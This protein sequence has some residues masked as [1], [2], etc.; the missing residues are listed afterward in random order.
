M[1]KGGPIGVRK[2][3]VLVGG[4]HAHLTVLVNLASYVQRG[5]RV[6][7]INPSPY[8]YYSGM[9]PGML[10]GIYRP[11]E[12][13]FHVKKMTEDRGGEF[14]ED[15][16]VKIDPF[17]RNLFLQGGKQ[18]PYDV[19]SFNTGSEVPLD[20]LF[21]VSQENIIPVK[22]VENLLRVHR[23]ILPVLKSGMHFTVIGGG[24]AGVEI[25]ANLWRLV[26]ESQGEAKIILIAGRK[27][28]GSFPEK[29][30][31][32]ALRSLS[33]RGIEVLEGTRVKEIRKELVILSE[34]RSLPFDFAFLALGIRPSSI[35]HE[36]GLPTGED[37]GLRVN[38]HLQSVAYPELFG[39]GD[40]ISLSGHP[41]AKVGVHAVRQNP[42]LFRN[43]VAALEGGEMQ[44]FI[45]QEDYLQILNMGDGRG[46]LWKKSFVWEGRLAFLLKDYI[47]RRFMRNFQVSGELEEGE[48]AGGE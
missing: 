16:V 10:S 34:G 21:A 9:S 35:F 17:N 40:C 30:R 38:S 42:L 3:L 46:I 22:P 39:G 29:V 8:Q 18:L 6:T 41:L 33:R 27:L 20:L 31:T 44:T 2:H 43:L 32:L 19:A 11:R 14:I 37:G 25:A 23:L 48:T 24:P 45:P 5:H 1:P 13:R 7:L 15:K 28:L 4:G 12:V 47:D 26:K 36:S